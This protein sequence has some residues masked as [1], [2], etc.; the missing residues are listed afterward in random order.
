MMDCLARET[1]EGQEDR[2]RPGQRQVPPRQGPDRPIRPR[3]GPGANHAHLHAPVRP[4]PWVPQNTCGTL[5]RAISPT[6]SAFAPENTFAAFTAYIT[7]RTFDY[8]FEHLPVTPPHRSCLIPAI[9][10]ALMPS[11]PVLALL[12]SALSLVLPAPAVLLVCPSPTLLRLALLL[13]SPE[14]VPLPLHALPPLPLL[15]P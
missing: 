8:D 13:L 10:P 4:R 1:D 5:P 14:L 3:S 15:P 2:S 12:P 9:P 7:N 6:S 11:S